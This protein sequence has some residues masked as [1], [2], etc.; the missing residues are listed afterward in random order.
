LEESN[1]NKLA[2]HAGSQMKQ[3]GQCPVLKR[4]RVYSGALVVYLVVLKVAHT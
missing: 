4:V 2:G 1:T 3:A